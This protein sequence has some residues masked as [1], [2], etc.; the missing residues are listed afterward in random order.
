MW[1][2]I[3]YALPYQSVAHYARAWFPLLFRLALVTKLTTSIY[4]NG[5][6]QIVFILFHRPASVRAGEQQFRSGFSPFLLLHPEWSC[7]QSKGDFRYESKWF[8]RW[9]HACFRCYSSDGE[10]VWESEGLH[11]FSIRQLMDTITNDNYVP[12]T[13]SKK[14]STVEWNT[15][16][17]FSAYRLINW[18]GF[19]GSVGNSFVLIGFHSRSEATTT[20]TF[21]NKFI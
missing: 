6:H 18:S 11:N 3:V 4:Q 20:R 14:M 7:F 5:P 8:A 1:Y 13:W 19:R 15:F 16:E 10:N 2:I 12:F 9:A 21:V 17:Y